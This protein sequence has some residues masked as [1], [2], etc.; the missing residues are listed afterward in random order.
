M[1][2]RSRQ[3]PLSSRRPVVLQGR[4]RMGNKGGIPLCLERS[5][6]LLGR[7]VVGG[8]DSRGWAVPTV[9]MGAHQLG[10]APRPISGSGETQH[11]GEILGELLQARHEAHVDA[12]LKVGPGSHHGNLFFLLRL[13]GNQLGRGRQFR[14]GSKNVPEEAEHSPTVWA[15]GQSLGAQ[16]PRVPPPREGVAMQP[17]RGHEHLSLWEFALGHCSFTERTCSPRAVS[18]EGGL[19]QISYRTC[20]FSAK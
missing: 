3:R 20:R 10:G 13:P 5:A 19:Y 1:P 6:W 12:V 15:N 7:G 8:R 18:H 4:P 2:I 9:L 17:L 14:Q 11:R 16:L